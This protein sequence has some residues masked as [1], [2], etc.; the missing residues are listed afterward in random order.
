MFTRAAG[1]AGAV[2]SRAGD[3]VAVAVF[4]A[5]DG[6]AEEE[7]SLH[8]DCCVGTSTAAAVVDVVGSGVGVVLVGA[9]AACAV[10]VR[11][12]TGISFGVFGCSSRDA[13]RCRGMIP[14]ASLS[15][16]NRPEYIPNQ[17]VC[18]SSVVRYFLAIRR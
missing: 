8:P 16:M 18:R 6:V 9:A 7:P 17:C 10:G 3:G 12:F 2:T 5:G 4:A 13:S 1:V 14:L 15:F 11:G